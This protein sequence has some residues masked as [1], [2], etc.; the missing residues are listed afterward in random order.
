MINVYFIKN[1]ILMIKKKKLQ[2]SS[3][4]TKISQEKERIAGSATFYCLILQ[5]Y[6]VKCQ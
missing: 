1:T 3:I 2:K 6:M 4:D 5:R